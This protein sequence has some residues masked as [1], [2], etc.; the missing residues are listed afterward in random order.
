MNNILVV[1]GVELPP[2][3][4]MKCSDYDLTDSERNAKGVMVM[5]MIRENIHKVE[6]TW[7]ILRPEQYM[8]IR[9]AIAQKYCL[10][11]K[12][13]IPDQ[14][15]KGEIITYAGDRTTPIYA[16]EGEQP[17]YKGFSLNFVEM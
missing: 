13:F 8:V 3:S 11:T 7:N 4:T 12:Y 2:P 6:C 17:V 5:Q 14:N 15:Q 10:K 1:N 16:F 9:N